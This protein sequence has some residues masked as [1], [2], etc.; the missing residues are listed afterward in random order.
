MKMLRLVIPIPEDQ[1]IINTDELVDVSN[2]ECKGKHFGIPETIIVNPGGE[3]KNKS[4]KLGKGYNWHLG[5]DSYGQI[6]LVPT[7]KQK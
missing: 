3:F 5:E 7:K 4:F 6:V 1:E 2:I